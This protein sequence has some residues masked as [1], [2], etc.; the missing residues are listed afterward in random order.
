MEAGAD[1]VKVGMGPG[2]ICATR[3]ISGMGYLGEKTIPE[4]QEKSQF[5]KISASFLKESHPHDIELTKESLNYQS[6]H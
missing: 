5:I 4:L 1:A 6:D 3:I 2:S